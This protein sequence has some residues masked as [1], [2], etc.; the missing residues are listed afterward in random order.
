MLQRAKERKQ[1]MDMDIDEDDIYGKRS[2]SVEEKLLNSNFSGDFVQ[3][4]KGHG[5]LTA[6]I[7]L[8]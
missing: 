6:S 5:K 4:L 7:F 1:Y 2:Y 8:D 3:E